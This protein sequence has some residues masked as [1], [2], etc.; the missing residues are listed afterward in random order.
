MVKEIACK[1]NEGISSRVQE[2]S[3]LITSNKHIWELKP[4]DLCSTYSDIGNNIHA[5]L[6]AMTENELDG[7]WRYRLMKLST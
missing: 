3:A 6:Q 2:L 4:I 5:V 7:L 1:Y